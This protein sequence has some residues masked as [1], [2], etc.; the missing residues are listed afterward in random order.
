MLRESDTKVD[1]IPL[2]P[3][4]N[5]AKLMMFHPDLVREKVGNIVLMGGAMYFGNVT[6]AAELNFY[7]DPEAANYDSLAD[8]CFTENGVELRLPWQLLNFASP[9][10]RAIHDD[11]YSNYGVEAVSIDELY[12]GLALEGEA[13]GRIRMT[14]FALEGWGERGSYSER[15]K[16]SYYI[17]QAAWAPL[18]K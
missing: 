6:A 3:L 9:A 10:D 5:I 7:A 16:E 12:A 2:A 14:P 1:L 18:E 13:E 8:Y 17:L 11:Y 15:L 4:T